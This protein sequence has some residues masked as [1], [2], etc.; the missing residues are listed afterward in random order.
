VRGELIGPECVVEVL[1]DVPTPRP[2]PA[3]ILPGGD[4]LAVAGFGAIILL[5]ALPWSRFGG[6][7]LFSAWRAQWS[8]VAII[9]S[10]FGLV[11]ALVAWRRSRDPG[12][13][14]LVYAGLALISGG[15][16][17]L[18]HSRPPPLTASS[19]VPLIA[20]AAAGVALLG[21]LVKGRSAI[22]AARY[23]P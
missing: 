18:Q 2:V 3:P 9:A 14:A 17:I 6:S 23:H 22:R 7:G 12:L 8:L 20:L 10:V 13:E 5:S 15:A 19:P 1:E 16:A 11:L 4:R 21:G